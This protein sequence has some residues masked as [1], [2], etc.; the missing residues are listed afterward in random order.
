MAYGKWIGAWIGAM[1][2]G[3][4]G[5]LAGFA[6]GSLFDKVTED[7]GSANPTTDNRFSGQQRQQEGARNGFLFSLMVLSAHIIQADG[8]IM[9]SEMETVRRFLRAHFGETAVQQGESILRRL[10]EYRNLNGEAMWNRQIQE[11]CL[12]M[13]G[14]M[15]EEHRMQLV[16]FLAEIAKADG[17]VDAV[18]VNALREVAA[19]LGLNAGMADQLLSLGSNTVDDAYKVLGVSSDATDEEVRSAYRKLVR[20]NHP[21]RVATLGTDVMEAAK[22]K[23]QE[24]N[25]AKERVYKVRGM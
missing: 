11:A 19:F 3:V 2:G 10:F 22:K 15:P 7:S 17:S 14:A 21:D 5:A 4:L 20:Q 1:S 6:I 9:H 23:M 12:E 16:A 8:K 18:E 24:I 25:D 13:R